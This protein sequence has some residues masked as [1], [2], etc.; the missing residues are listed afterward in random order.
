VKITEEKGETVL[1]C[2]AIQF[3]VEDRD[4]F[5]PGE[6]R[7]L[8]GTVN[9]DRSLSLL[10]SSLVGSFPGVERDAMGNGIQPSTHRRLPP[11]RPHAGNQDQERGLEGII[12]VRRVG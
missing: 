12:D 6:V 9:L 7:Q 10:G 8:S 1:V 5:A 4:C 11:E 3:F 2:E